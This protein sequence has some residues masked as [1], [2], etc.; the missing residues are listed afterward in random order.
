MFP[1]FCRAFPI[2]EAVLCMYVI[3]F[4]VIGIFDYY[5]TLENSDDNY[6]SGTLVQEVDINNQ[7][8][9]G[10]GCVCVWVWVRRQS[11][12]PQRHP[13]PPCRMSTE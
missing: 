13:H 12:N 10:C 6:I 1:C 9:A 3:K 2:P 7:A 5:R 11:S 8:L 4:T